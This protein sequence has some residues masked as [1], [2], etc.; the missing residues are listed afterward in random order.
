MTR[1][2]GLI[3][4]KGGVGKSTIVANLAVSLAQLGHQ[5]IAVDANLTTPNLGLHLGLHLA[6]KTIHDVLKGTSRIQE[7]I[8]PHPLGFKVLPASIN[9]NDLV[10]V[11]VERLHDVT[12]SL[13][14]KYDYV[15]LDC[16]A[17]LGREAITAMSACD[18]ILIITN[19]DLPSV[20]D[21]LKTKEIAKGLNKR[22]AGVIVNRVRNKWYEIPKWDIEDML[23]EKIIAEIPEDINVNKTVFLKIPLVDYNPDTPAAIEMRRLAHFLTGRSFDIKYKQKYSLLDRLV[24]WVV[25]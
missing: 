6:S 14:G 15:L 11:D 1:I 13:I 9:V 10:D 7:A 23:G 18:E 22:V 12:I 25:G 20:T 21:A 4:G 16:A 24:N 5:V 8:Y 17:G 19:P 2:I 3:G